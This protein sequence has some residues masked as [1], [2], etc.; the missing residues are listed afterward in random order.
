MN[1][2]PASSLLHAQLQK[3]TYP[4]FETSTCQILLHKNASVPWFILVPKTDK[5]DLFDLD[6]SV[7]HI[8]MSEC[9]IIAGFLKSI[10]GIDKINYAT[11]G[12]LVPQL[13][14]HIIGRTEGDACWP[15]PV[16]GHLK[17][18]VD[19]TDNQLKLMTQSLKNYFKASQSKVE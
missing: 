4:L 13:H 8:I 7:R 1:T 10:P 9:K 6:E 3:D 17:D 15:Q 2:K 18:Y 11:I 12:N 16:W 19:Y 5:T 14:L